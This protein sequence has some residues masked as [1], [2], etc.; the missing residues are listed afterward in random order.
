MPPARNPASVLA[1]GMPPAPTP[2]NDPSFQPPVTNG[3]LEP[4]AQES[5]LQ[6]QC[7]I[8]VNETQH[9]RSAKTNTEYDRCIV[10]WRAYCTEERFHDNDIVYLEKMIAYL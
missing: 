7:Q 3:L 10:A 8:Q 4:A 5:L 9:L 6:V 2:S 1:A